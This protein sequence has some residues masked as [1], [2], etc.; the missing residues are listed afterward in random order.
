[1]TSLTSSKQTDGIQQTHRPQTT[2]RTQLPE[3]VGKNV[4]LNRRETDER[5]GKYF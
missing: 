4:R 2:V 3:H 5:N 1:M